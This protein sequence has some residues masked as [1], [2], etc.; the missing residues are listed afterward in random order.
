MAESSKYPRVLVVALGR[1]NTVDSYNNGLL[2]RNL[3]GSWPREYLA[4]IYS[5]G[6]TGDEGFF[7]DYYQLGPQDRRLGRLF[8]R[9]KAEALGEAAKTILARKAAA[10]HTA[11][12]GSWARHL[13]VDTGLYEI[14]FAPRLS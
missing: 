2:L 6:D 13:L 1:I 7:G 3:F 8:Y 9:L 10:A 5:S 4:Q 11:S 14:V 12:A